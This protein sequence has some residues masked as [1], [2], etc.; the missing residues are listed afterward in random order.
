[1]L[2]TTCTQVALAARNS[3]FYGDRIFD[4]RA[5][6][7][8]RSSLQP[9]ATPWLQLHTVAGEHSRRLITADRVFDDTVDPRLVLLVAYGWSPAAERL[10]A[11]GAPPAALVS[12]ES[13]VIAW[14]P[15]YQG[16]DRRV[17]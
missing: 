15:Y 11:Q 17:A 1:M 6:A 5:I 16:P 10:V 12:F 13:P 4:P 3:E 7:A 9:M 2:G 14:W 8:I